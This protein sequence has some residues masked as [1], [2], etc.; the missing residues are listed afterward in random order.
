[1]GRSHGGKLK[2]PPDPEEICRVFFFLVPPQT[3]TQCSLFSWAEFPAWF[4]LKQVM[5]GWL[6]VLTE[7]ERGAPDVALLSVRKEKSRTA[8]LNKDMH[9]NQDEKDCQLCKTIFP[10]QHLLIRGL[11]VLSLTLINHVSWEFP[12]P[13]WIVLAL[14]IICTGD[15]MP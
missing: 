6:S 8:A 1:M 4:F 3:S 14:V 5:M 10:C 9:R 2:K 7:W 15:E 13:R 12:L 11:F